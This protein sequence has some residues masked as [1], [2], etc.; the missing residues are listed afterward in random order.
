MDP[1]YVKVDLWP[2]TDKFKNV[3]KGPRYF[4]MIQNTPGSTFSMFKQVQNMSRHLVRSKVR[5]D[6]KMICLD[7]F[8]N[9]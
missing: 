2:V 7:Y 6:N 8:R 5:L 4:R 3:E 9:V 1:K